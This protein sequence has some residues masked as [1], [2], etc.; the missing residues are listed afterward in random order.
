MSVSSAIRRSSLR[1]SSAFL[2]SSGGGAAGREAEA[3]RRPVQGSGP[4]DQR[5]CLR[6]SDNEIMKIATHLESTR[7]FDAADLHW[8]EAGGRIN[9]SVSSP[10]RGSSVA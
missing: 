10:A 9:R 4:F 7:L 5:V 3:W 1:S 8:L 6:G 2:P